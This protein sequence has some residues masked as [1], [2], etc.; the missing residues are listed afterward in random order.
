MLPASCDESSLE[1][2]RDS[3]GSRE[4]AVD[5]GNIEPAAAKAG[6][7]FHGITV[8]LKAYPDTNRVSKLRTS[9]DESTLDVAR[10]SRGSRENAVDGG[11]IEPAAAKAGHIFH[12]ITVCLKA[13]PDTN[14]D[15]CMPEGI[16]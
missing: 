6:H 11:N 14:R 5:G 9:C 8:C 12:R 3:R 1:V 4:N 2:A 13:Y 10:D 15:Y 7:I 16:P